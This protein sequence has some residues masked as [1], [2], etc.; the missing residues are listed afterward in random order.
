MTNSK[1]RNLD[2]AHLK[3]HYLLTI[4]TKKS[5]TS[6]QTCI[7]D[8]LILMT[9]KSMQKCGLI[10]INVDAMY[11]LYH[12]MDIQSTPLNRVTG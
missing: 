10:S 7:H 5:M 12:F 6:N 2:S 11:A 9:E 8:L 1:L 4:M 3:V